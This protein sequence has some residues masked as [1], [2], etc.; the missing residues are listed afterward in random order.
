MQFLGSL[1]PRQT[2][3]S[4]CADS[5][6]WAVRCDARKKR[7]LRVRIKRQQLCWLMRSRFIDTS[8]RISP[9]YLRDKLNLRVRQ[10]KKYKYFMALNFAI[11]TVLVKCHHARRPTSSTEPRSHPLTKFTATCQILKLR[12][13][14]VT[15][16]LFNNTL[17]RY[18]HNQ[19]IT[20]WNK[21]NPHKRSP[22]RQTQLGLDGRKDKYSLVAS[23]EHHRPQSLQ[24]FQP[25]HLS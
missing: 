1:R 16:N 10:Q 2:S 5:L 24:H 11:A 9:S 15:R 20:L 12:S 7:N 19:K 6:A 22:R 23:A 14:D 21:A 18:T 25:R 13:I 8:S 3:A 4:K 17:K